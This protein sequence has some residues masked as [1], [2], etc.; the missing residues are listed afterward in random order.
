MDIHG[1]LTESLSQNLNASLSI[2]TLLT[3]RKIELFVYPCYVP[4]QIYFLDL[5]SCLGDT[6]LAASSLWVSPAGD[7]DSTPPWLFLHPRLRQWKNGLADVVLSTTQGRYL[8]MIHCFCLLLST[9]SKIIGWW[10][11]HLKTDLLCDRYGQAERQQIQLC[12]HASYLCTA[13]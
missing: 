10:D 13:P 12:F 8:R 1:V 9:I 2:R 7:G 4:K 6:S 11:F 3:N 5:P